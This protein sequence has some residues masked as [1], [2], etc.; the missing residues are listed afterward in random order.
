M[1]PKKEKDIPSNPFSAEF[2]GEQNQEPTQKQEIIDSDTSAFDSSPLGTA[3]EKLSALPSQERK[4]KYSRTKNENGQY[5]REK[6]DESSNLT[7]K[8]KQ[9]IQNLAHGYHVEIQPQHISL[10][11]ELEYI[12]S[13]VF[14]PTAND[15]SRKIESLVQWA[16]QDTNSS[17]YL[18]ASQIEK[19]LAEVLQ[20]SQEAPS[21]ATFL[22]IGKLERIKNYNFIEEVLAMHLA[23]DY[24]KP[25]GTVDQIATLLRL[26][27]P[28]TNAMGHEVLDFLQS[29][30]ELLQNTFDESIPEGPLLTIMKELKN[31]IE[32]TPNYLLREHLKDFINTKTNYHTTEAAGIPGGASKATAFN[33]AHIEDSYHFRLR[34][35]NIGAI[36]MNPITRISPLHVGYYAH[37]QLR[38][39]Y[40]RPEVEPR[41]IKEYIKQNEPEY[42]NFYSFFN[43]EALNAIRHKELDPSMGTRPLSIILELQETLKETKEQFFIDIDQINNFDELHPMVKQIIF[44]HNLEY[45]KNREGED[46]PVPVSEEEYK[47][48]ISPTQNLTSA[49]DLEYRQLMSSRMRKEI[50]D[51][52]GIDLA[53]YSF[54]VQRHFLS[55]VD[56]VTVDEVERLQA[57]VKEYG[58]NGLKA[59]LALEQDSE[60]AEKILTIADTLDQATAKKLFGKFTEIADQ[61]DT[62]REYLNQHFEGKAPQVEQVVSNLLR[63]AGRII[64]S[65]A[66]K[67]KQDAE[68]ISGE[69]DS[70]NTDVLIFSSAFQALQQEG[71]D[72][73]LAEIANTEFE[74]VSMLDLPEHEREEVQNELKA[75]MKTNYTLRYPEKIVAIGLKGLE[76]SF[77]NPNSRVHIL[78]HEGTIMG[79]F[80]IDERQDDSLYLGSVNIIPEATG[81]KLG[82]AMMKEIID[83]ESEDKKIEADVTLELMPYYIEKFGFVGVSVQPDYH[84]TGETLFGIEI[85]RAAT[86][87]FAPQ[88]SAQALYFDYHKL[89]ARDIDETYEFET[90]LKTRLDKTGPDKFYITD[91]EI[92]KE[93]NQTVVTLQKALQPE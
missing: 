38:E 37:G 19:K 13:I 14:N 23:K 17:R 92:D 80:R 2:N 15:C 29:Y 32:N 79:F 82:E 27:T 52:F 41:Q 48:L 12:K 47:A 85:D 70:L 91:W 44:A 46:S 25:S 42:N 58:E 69:L 60:A 65:N 21:I 11:E 1:S 7:E 35:M 6:S 18:R 86:P 20:S 45:I 50:E 63:R 90:E 54:W 87:A 72:I 64:D 22:L 62:I 30:L 78:R 88:S 55:Y 40:T 77:E 26:N 53:D 10:D 33:S 8:A 73:P 66:T 4:I 39:I 16:A 59:F 71:I 56:R 28:E 3:F 83:V 75:Q 93:N 43:K 81:S 74:S 5:E 57:F 68:R 51:G 49:Q 61:T 31:E 67:T 24:T 9:E 36:G 76:A 89:Q 34:G 84:G